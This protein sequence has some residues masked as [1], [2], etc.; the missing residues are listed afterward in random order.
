[1]NFGPSC[2]KKK[3]ADSSETLLAIYPS[4]YPEEGGRRFFEPVGTFIPPNY[5][6]SQTINPED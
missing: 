6:A 5:T 1:L 4:S 2:I 3:A